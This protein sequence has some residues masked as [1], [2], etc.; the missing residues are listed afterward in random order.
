MDVKC[1][2]SGEQSD[3][4]LL[5]KIRPKDSIKFVVKDKADCCFAQDIIKSHSIKGEIFFSPVYG[6]DYT[7]IQKFVLDNN[8]PVRMQVQLH[9]IFGVK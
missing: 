1:P 9:K 6:T 7:T 3:L 4:S 8:L 5:E 2:S